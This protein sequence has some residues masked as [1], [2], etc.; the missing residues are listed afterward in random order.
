MGK[1]L[2]KPKSSWFNVGYILKMIW[3]GDR[4]IVIYSMFKAISEN[5]FY[6][7][8]F[9]YLTKYIYTC[10]EQHTAFNEMVQLVA[11]LCGVHVLL[12]I[13]SAGHQYYL[14]CHTPEVYRYIISWIF[15]I[16]VMAVRQHM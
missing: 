4:G 5:I 9:V 11:L 13:S 12:Y 6:V 2:N 7:F 10:I 14:K 15:P 16:P 3:Q 8:F 1:Q